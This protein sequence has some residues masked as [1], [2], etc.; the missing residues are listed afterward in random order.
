MV[1]DPYQKRE[2]KKYKNPIPSREYIISW[3]KKNIDF[4]T[5]KKLENIFNINNKEG[6]KA[7]RRRLRAMERDRQIVYIS[8]KCYT[9][10]EKLQIIHGTVIGHRD[11][12]GFLR[13]ETLQDDLWLSVEQMKL[14]IHGDVVS[15]YIIDTDRKGRSSAKIL[16]ILKPNNNLIVGRYYV[17]NKKNFVIPDDVRF[18]FKIYVITNVKKD[19]LDGSIVVVQLKKYPRNKYQAEG[20]IVE[21]LGEKMGTNL[22]IEIALRTHSIPDQWSLEVRNQ[23]LNIKNTISHNDRKNRADLRHLPFFTIDDED[24]RDFDD[25]IFCKKKI[26]TEEEW[27]LWVAIADVS[28]YVKPNT[29][30]DKIASERGNSIYFPSRVI[31]M[32]PEKISI[33]LCSLNPHVERLC[34]VCQM[35]LSSKGA[36]ISY[37]HYEAI[38]SSHGR[39][40]YNQILKIWNG[41][42]LL[43]TKYKKELKYIINLF[44]LQK[45]FNM[46][47]FDKKNIDF[48]NIEPKFI[49]DSNLRIHKIYQNIRHDVHKFIES[50]MIL[51]N[52]ASSFLV[53]KYKYPVL[54][55]NHDK[56]SNNNIISFRFFLKELGLKLCGGDIPES[57]HYSNLLKKSSYRSD[58]E[59]IQNMLLRSMKQAVYS[60]ENRG[61]FGL[62]LSS[63][64]HFTSPIRRYPDLLVHRVIKFLILKEKKI[65][66][67]KNHIYNINL[68]NLKEAER[69]GIHCSMTERRA[70]N[71]VRDVIDWLKCDFMQKKIGHILKGVISNVTSFG[72]FVRL[73]SL[74]IDG[75]VHIKTLSDDYYYFDS[76]RLRLIGKSHKKTYRLGDSLDVKV[77][78]INSH[79]RKIEL[80]LCIS[81]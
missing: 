67:N 9:I 62:C 26:N 17:N 12:Y 21:I 54:F 34:L 36:L 69:L 46:Y 60:P 2:A 22:A 56:P 48:E 4:I 44:H 70:D 6:R 68:I 79:E 38:I 75:L 77:I 51:A 31:P 3:L 45:V 15:A 25:A 74:F 78:A 53:K 42:V 29:A 65:F 66:F 71:A 63:Y 81:Y 8:N 10:P 61:H 13:T 7:L 64:V 80:S 20:L 23:L 35:H 76:L 72:L 41:D 16:K 58:Y 28:A 52:I 19:I 32:L 11:G 40:T 37:K 59:I 1:V 50:C 55:R 30:L 14:C 5:L 27:D 57:I 24:A 18:N 49:L 39:F 73:N 33:D 43:C 47:K